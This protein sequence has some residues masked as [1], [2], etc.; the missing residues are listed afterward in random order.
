MP[1]PAA[2]QAFITK[3]QLAGAAERA[4]AQLFMAELCDVQA[5]QS[6]PA[7]VED[8]AGHFEGK[9]T[10]KRLEE[11]ERLLQTLAAV[12]RARYVANKDGGGWAGSG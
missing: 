3:W 4:N 7:T 11:M 1:T 6:A 8:I 2:L 9:R 10:K 12:G 5:T